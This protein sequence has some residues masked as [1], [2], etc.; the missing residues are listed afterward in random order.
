MSD[1]DKLCGEMRRMSEHQLP[2]SG[3]RVVDCTV[4][5]GELTFE[6]DDVPLADAQVRSQ[7]ARQRV[8]QFCDVT[9]AHRDSAGQTGKRGAAAGDVHAAAQLLHPGSC[10]RKQPVVQ[11]IDAAA[12][13]VLPRDHELGGG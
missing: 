4:E 1:G 13:F 7:Q 9:A 5:R 12:E 10:S 2:L 11:A 6:L 8:R 3:L